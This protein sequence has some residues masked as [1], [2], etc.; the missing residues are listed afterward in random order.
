MSLAEYAVKNAKFT[1]FA[2]LMLVLGGLTAFKSLGQLEGPEF[3]IKTAVI[4]TTYPGASPE[5]VEQEVTER[6]E[7]KLQEIK[8]IDVIESVSRAGFSSIS[9]DIQPQ[10][11]SAQLPQIWDT[12]RRKV[13][14]V[15]SQLPPG[16]GRPFIND[17]FGDVFG[18]VL[19]VTSDGFS[20]SELKDY[21]DILK[22][23]LSLVDG[24]GRVDLWGE[25]DRAIY[26]DVREENL[27]ELGISE[28]TLERTIQFQNAVSDSGSVNVGEYRMRIA[29]T[30]AFKDPKDI[31]NL[32][33]QPALTD[34]IQSKNQQG[35]ETIRLGQ[36]GEIRE[37]Y[38]EPPNT[39]LRYNSEVAI[40]LSISFQSG[41]NVVQVGAAVDTKLAELLPR[42]PIGIEVR[43]VHWQS[44]DVDLAVQS[45]LI[46]LAQ[47]VIIV[48]VVL[49]LA[50]GLRMGIII[51]TGLLLT[52]LATFIF[53]AGLGIDLQRM[54]L[55]ALI[56]AL[57]MMVDNSIVV[58]DGAA[59]RMGRG[60]DRVK[61]AV[62]AAG[63]P[64]VSLLAAT[65]VAVMAF[66]P[67]YAS[68]ESAGEY[69]RTLFSVVAI[70]LL[71]SW[72][73]SMTV[74]PAQ[75]V[76]MLPEPKSSQGEN[77]DTGIYK[78][79]R[80]IL[81]TAMRLRYITISV[82]VVALVA[83]GLAFG[84]VTQLF[85][86][87]SAMTKFMID[88]YAPEGTRIEAVSAA[89]DKIEVQLKEDSRITGVAS[90]IGA[91]PPRFYLPVDPEA[92]NQAYAQLIVNVS[93]F[94]EIPEIAKALQPWLNENLP[95]AT[96]FVRQFGVGPSNTWTF[97]A[98]IVGPADANPNTL[99]AIGDE[100][101]KV[102]EK[103]PW[104][105][106]ARTDWRNQV[107]KSV[108]AYDQD[109]ARWTGITPED[110]SR[111]TKRAYDGR[112]IG[113]Y[114]EEDELIPILLRHIEED[115]LAVDNFEFLQIQSQL[116]T[117]P[118]PL[119]QVVKEVTTK[120][121]NP[122]IHRRDRRRNLTIQANPIDS[123][124]LPT[125]RSS[126]LEEFASLEK[127]LPPGYSLEW[128]GEFED[129]VK[130]QASLTPGMIPALAVMVLVVVGLFNAYRTPLVI[131]LTIPFMIIGIVPGLLATD[132][133]FGFVALLGAMSLSGMMI[134]NAIVLIDQINDNIADGEELYDAIVN[135]GA[136]R[137]RP[138][139]LAAATTVL[140]V[141]PLLP[142][143]FWAGL[144]VTLMSGLTVGTI[145]TMIMVPVLYATL[146]GVPSP[147]ENFNV[148][149][150]TNN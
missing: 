35:L 135:A 148:K 124:T 138:V 32:V 114:R 145:L 71:L 46:S 24:V 56:I 10:Y 53:L 64:S 105:K 1:W 67:I 30:G 23:E 54:S 42:L 25:Q 44:D 140:G 5:E 61:A 62:Q 98:R 115:A 82:A 6:I 129:T 79:Y 90:F 108:P 147:K 33:I 132:T 14:D 97:E 9:V 128:G 150:V 74:T 8:E 26:F 69:C 111:T 93:D 41:V 131:F 121:E 73:I 59:V 37:G 48:L 75:C 112:K 78:I 102:L 122:M 57:G 149:A 89:I 120:S 22:R 27:V 43:K 142:D 81:G 34:A 139:A 133:P 134:K 92:A 109:R 95:E 117:K 47:A 58:A 127:G 110:L 55:G 60:M 125:Y 20:Y 17:D 143:V 36:I 70:A 113:L 50:M 52:I 88:Y 136:A 38:Q 94:K 72:I 66:Y 106:V 99:R 86:P 39:L 137:L 51:G 7:L 29:P 126:V 119:A 28:E 107:W 12:L 18:L 80:R 84:S 16:A 100:A 31:E 83:S 85:F 11:W 21:V 141:I 2:V 3:T 77:F 13:R 68:V 101:V 19:A 65:F 130:S 104:T 63:R 76:L 96:T 4:T 144:A 40:G 118:V 103:H 123:I 87:T 45:F 49:T 91:G 146:Y 116:S 15:E